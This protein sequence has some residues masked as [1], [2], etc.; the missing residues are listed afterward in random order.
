VTGAAISPDGKYIAYDDHTGLYL[1]SIDS[2]ETR[3]VSVPAGFQNRMGSL[4]WFPDGGKLLAEVAGSGVSDVDLWVITTLGGAAPRLLYRHAGHPA[5]SPNGR[6]IAFVSSGLQGEAANAAVLVGGVNGEPPRRLAT[7]A[8]TQLLASPTWSPD[9]RWIAYARITSLVD[10]SY[11][12]VIEVRP[13]GGGP[14]K[15]LVSPASLPPSSSPCNRLA[16][17][18]LRWSPHRRLVFAVSQTAGPSAQA[19]Y[20]LW[21][22]P[23]EPRSGQAAGRPER[24]WQWG[25]VRVET[26]MTFGATS[27]TIS[28]DA[29]R[30]CF[31]KNNSWPD[32]YVGELSPDGTSMKPPRRFTLDGR[33]SYPNSWTRDSEAI[34][35]H[36]RS[37]KNE[38]LRQGLSESVAA[39][40][41]QSSMNCDIPVLSSDGSWILYEESTPSPPGAARSLSR[42]MRLPLA[43]GLSETVLDEPGDMWWYYRCPLKPGSSCVLSQY[44]GKDLVFYALDPVRG[45]GKQLG[46]MEVSPSRA[47]IWDISPDGSRVTLVGGYDLYQGKVEVLTFGDPVPHEVRVEPGWGIFQSV[48]WTVDGKGFFVTGWPPSLLHVTATGKVSPLLRYTG[49]WMWNPTP[50]PDGKHLAYQA[51][52]QDSNV[53]ML[54]DF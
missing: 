9:G 37:G 20:S 16:D 44:E 18:C 1:R 41:T 26:G 49:Q 28:A 40:V 5:I 6:L 43:G 23:M 3:P 36:S 14:A 2:G 10:I 25:G 50:S 29:K 38:I 45:K 35:L 39:T 32:A 19:E 12:G 42:L 51:S 34:I 30:L 47:A 54:E 8:S 53:W 22:I 21:E 24:L 33:G 52:T 4:E 17:P 11:A 48:S 7:V 13:A 27:P 46:K 15:T 31:L